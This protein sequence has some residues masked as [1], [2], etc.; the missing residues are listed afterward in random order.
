MNLLPPNENSLIDYHRNYKT[1][2]IQDNHHH[3][4]NNE[5]HYLDIS[6]IHRTSAF[7][8]MSEDPILSM[9]FF[10]RDGLI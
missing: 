5:S 10:K 4:N 6:P 2:E 9:D 1:E 3:N 7:S 8:N